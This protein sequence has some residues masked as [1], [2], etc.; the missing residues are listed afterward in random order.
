MEAVKCWQIIYPYTD[1]DALPIAKELYDARIAEKMDPSKE[2]KKRFSEAQKMMK[3][4]IKTKM[5]N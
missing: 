1:A 3:Q 5:K 2:N 4:Y